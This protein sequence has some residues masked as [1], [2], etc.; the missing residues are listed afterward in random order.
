MSDPGIIRFQPLAGSYYMFLRRKSY[1]SR[2]QGVSEF[3]GDCNL[4]AGF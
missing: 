2:G 1:V 4:G 3:K